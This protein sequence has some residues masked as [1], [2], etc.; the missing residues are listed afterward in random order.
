MKKIEY[1]HPRNISRVTSSAYDRWYPV[2]DRVATAE[3]MTPRQILAYG[4][5]TIDNRLCFEKLLDDETERTNVQDNDSLCV[6]VTDKIFYV[7][8]STI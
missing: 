7:L 8:E 2:A 6:S 3:G 1:C 5:L 4:Y